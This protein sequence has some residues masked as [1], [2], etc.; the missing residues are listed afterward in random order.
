MNQKVKMAHRRLTWFMKS[1]LD[2]KSFFRFTIHHQ[3]LQSDLFLCTILLEV[4]RK[5]SKTQTDLLHLLIYI[6]IL[7][8]KVYIIF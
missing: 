1:A 4:F 6:A 8:H 2:V 7:I 5:K 3:R